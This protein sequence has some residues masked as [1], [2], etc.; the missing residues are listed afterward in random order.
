MLFLDGVYVTR[1]ED[2]LYFRRVQPPTAAELDGL[3]AFVACLAHS[4]HLLLFRN[5]LHPAPITG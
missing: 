2:G 4:H 5:K 3:I 1:G